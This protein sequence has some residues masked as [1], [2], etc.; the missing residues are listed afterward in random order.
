MAANSGSSNV[1]DGERGIETARAMQAAAAEALGIE[2]G[3]VGVAST[4]V[5]GTELPRETVV[6]GV[7]QLLRR[8]RPRDAGF[9]EAILTSDRG[10]KRACLEVELSSAGPS[11]SRARRRAP[12]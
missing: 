2:S 6:N 8:A 12:G 4:G 7:G 1:G 10:P 5:I 11:G 9:S 3:Q